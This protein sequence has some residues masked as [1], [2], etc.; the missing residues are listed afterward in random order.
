MK[1]ITISFRFH[2]THRHANMR[3]RNTHARTHASTHARTHHPVLWPQVGSS[4]VSWWSC[5]YIIQVWQI[6]RS[7]PVAILE[8][9]FFSSLTITEIS[10]ISKAVVEI[11]QS[12]DIFLQDKQTPTHSCTILWKV[13]TVNAREKE[14]NASVLICHLPSDSGRQG[15]V[16]TSM[17]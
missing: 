4:P 8:P 1:H 15:D 10:G 17:T 14:N 11:G 3:A 2:F 7:E 9:R 6:Q 12:R 13:E 5:S 16:P